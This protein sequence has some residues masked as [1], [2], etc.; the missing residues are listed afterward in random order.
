MRPKSPANDPELFRARLDNILNLDH[1]PLCRLAA[2]IDWARLEAELATCYHPENRSAGQ[3]PP[4][5]G[6]AALSQARL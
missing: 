4:L 5:A 6:G 2:K 3:C 1:H